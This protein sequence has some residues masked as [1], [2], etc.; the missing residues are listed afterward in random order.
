MLTHVSIHRGTLGLPTHCI[1]GKNGPDE[2]AAT[3]NIL[4]PATIYSESTL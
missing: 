2:L 1:F 3:S 4:E